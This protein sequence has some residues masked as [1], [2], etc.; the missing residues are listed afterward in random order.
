MT[1]SHNVNKD[2]AQKGLEASASSNGHG[3]EPGEWTPDQPMLAPHPLAELFPPLTEPDLAALTTDIKAQ[4]LREPIWLYEGQILDGRN[5]YRACQQLG[6]ACPTRTYTGDDPLGFVVSANLYRRH[7]NESQRAM[8]AAKLANMRQGARTDVQPPANL[9]EVS[10]AQAAET[11][12]ISE[13][14]VRHAKQVQAEGEP[15]LIQAVEAGHLAVTAAV[16]L[17]KRPVGLQR[18]VVREL[19]SGAATTVATALKHVTE[20]TYGRA[21]PL[22]RAEEEFHRRLTQTDQYFAKVAASHLVEGLGQRFAEEALGE[23]EQALRRLSTV[24]QELAERLV[25]ALR[26]TL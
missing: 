6:I 18:A 14:L 25:K 16:Q 1:T 15:E 13:R 4:G 3:S 8:V 11:L 24:T 7:L 2:T 12:N 5:R 17:A 21:G 19:E 22:T 9:P 23:W 20:G 26:E 10:T